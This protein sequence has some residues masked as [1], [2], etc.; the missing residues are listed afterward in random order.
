METPEYEAYLS[1]V[2]WWKSFYLFGFFNGN[3]EVYGL[4]VQGESNLHNF[5]KLWGKSRPDGQKKAF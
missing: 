1:V 4:K 2:F 3:F 5:H